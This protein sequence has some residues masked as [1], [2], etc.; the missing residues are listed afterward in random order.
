M[1]ITGQDDTLAAWVASQAKLS[2][3][4]KYT[5]IGSADSHGNLLGAT[6]FTNYHP[7]A[8]VIEMSSAAVSPKWLSREMINAI[9]TYPF[10]QLGCQMVVLRVSP[11]NSR[12]LNI[13]QKFGFNFYTIPRLRGRNEDEVILTFTAEQW[14]DCPYRRVN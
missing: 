8:G 2:G 12:M 7:E 1:L 11:H 14:R 5:A 13:G 4:E 10:D 6:V 3:F 9:F